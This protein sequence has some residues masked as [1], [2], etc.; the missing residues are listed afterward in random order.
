M[1]G[2]KR[3]EQE[4]LQRSGKS[5]GYL[6]SIGKEI[7]VGVIGA[8]VVGSFS[9]YLTRMTDF[10]RD[11]V[12]HYT[13][14]G[15]ANLAEGDR[16]SLLAAQNASV[17]QKHFHQANQHYRVAY[18]CGFSDA[19]LRLAVAHCMGLGEPKDARRA[20]QYV[21]DVEGKFPEKQRRADD[22][23]KACNL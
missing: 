10:G 12:D 9:L 3:G 14:E 15:K 11:L 4:T 18:N 2:R 20:R 21:L 1:F 6:S 22:V 16:L 17:A 13:C 7:V 23:R 8:V 5:D 19:G